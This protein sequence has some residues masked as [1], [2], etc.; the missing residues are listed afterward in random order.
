M[1]GN[2]LI[3]VGLLAAACVAAW[4]AL[5]ALGRRAPAGA[6]R[7]LERLPLEPRR[8][9]VLVQVG[10][11]VFLVGVGDGPMA[12]LAEVDRPELPDASEPAVQ[13]AWRRVVGGRA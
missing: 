3:T 10:G 1:D 12:L 2:A 9:L 5:R 7:V 6:M 8:S 4:L 11:R 13:R